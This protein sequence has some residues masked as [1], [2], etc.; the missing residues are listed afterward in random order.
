VAL[1]TG[2]RSFT[3]EDRIHIMPVDRLWTPISK[4]G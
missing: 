3:Y 1:S 4:N 2:L